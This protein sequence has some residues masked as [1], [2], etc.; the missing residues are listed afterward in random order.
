MVIFQQNEYCSEKQNKKPYTIAEFWLMVNRFRS[1]A[2]FELK[3]L[4]GKEKKYY[5]IEEMKWFVDQTRW[6]GY[7]NSINF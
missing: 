2:K 4:E 3:P 1:W 7:Q 6:Y 5:W